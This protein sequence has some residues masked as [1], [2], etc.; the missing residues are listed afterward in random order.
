MIVDDDNDGCCL[1]DNDDDMAVVVLGLF[2]SND[3]R[4][5]QGIRQWNAGISAAADD[6]VAVADNDC[7]SHRQF[8]HRHLLLLV[9]AL[10]LL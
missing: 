4:L 10:L 9:D 6:D 1:V 7:C 8:R 2:C 5:N 3:D